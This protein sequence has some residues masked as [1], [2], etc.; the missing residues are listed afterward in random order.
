MG[1]GEAPLLHNI[2]KITP[3]ECSLTIFSL[4]KIYP[5]TFFLHAPPV[6]SWSQTTLEKRY[7][8]KRN[9]TKISD[10][11]CYHIDHVSL[12]YLPKIM[13]PCAPFFVKY[14]PCLILLCPPAAV[15]C[16]PT[17]YK[18]L[19]EDRNCCALYKLWV[20]ITTSLFHTYH[21]SDMKMLGL[22]E[23]WPQPSI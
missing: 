14:V 8:T 6:P 9:F 12:L 17:S 11:V 19:W 20:L 1:Q 3:L 18:P 2:S 22:F 16:S 13:S 10:T 5:R 4:D 21:P 23:I 7:C 15:D